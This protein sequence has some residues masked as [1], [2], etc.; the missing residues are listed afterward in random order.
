[1]GEMASG[2]LTNTYFKILKETW[3]TLVKYSERRGIDW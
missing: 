3:S 1:M 2:N